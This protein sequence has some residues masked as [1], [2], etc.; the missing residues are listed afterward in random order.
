MNSSRKKYWLSGIILCLVFVLGIF[1]WISVK[2]EESSQTVL[3]HTESILPELPDRERI[4][5]LQTGNGKILF[6]VCNYEQETETLSFLESELLQIAMAEED[7]LDA[8]VT[9]G[10]C[11]YILMI[12]MI[13]GEE[14]LVVKQLQ[15][16]AER[17]VCCLDDYFARGRDDCYQWK[18]AAGG[19]NS[20]YIYHPYGY[21]KFSAEGEILDRETWPDAESYDM[22]ISDCGVWYSYFSGGERKL[23]YRDWLTGDEKWISLPH[24]GTGLWKMYVG[25]T[26]NFYLLE[27]E[28]LFR[29][30]FADSSLHKVLSWSDYGRTSDEMVGLVSDKGNISC[31]FLKN[32]NW[33]ILSWILDQRVE[34]EIVILGG[35]G[36][37][38]TIRS[39]AAHFNQ[40]QEEYL[41]EVVDY[42][43]SYSYEEQNHGIQDLYHAI[44][45]GNGPD[46]IAINTECMDYSAI[47]KNHILEDLIPYMEGSGLLKK[48]DIIQP[49]YN[50]LEYNGA[51]GMIP[52]NFYVRSWMVNRR[53]AG[54]EN[55]TAE[56]ILKIMRDNPEEIDSRYSREELLEILYGNCDAEELR[57][58]IGNG[59][60]GQALEILSSY[61]ES[62]IYESNWNLYPAG[63]IAFLDYGFSGVEDYLYGRAIWGEQGVYLGES[64]VLSPEIYLRNCWGISSRSKHKDVAWSFIES[65]FAKDWLENQASFLGFSANEKYFSRQLEQA[66]EGRLSVDGSVYVETGN[67][68]EVTR[69]DIQSLYDLVYHVNKMGDGNG[70]I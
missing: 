29:Y 56:K 42:G 60:L 33:E 50:L 26:G 40:A 63:K 23:Q 20:F 55:V 64:D 41:I 31:L 37:T 61:P 67:I 2:K 18:I 52:T 65:F 51:V 5:F 57:D 21:M 17:I 32:N 28:G 62:G 47:M 1:L 58:R 70:Q 35:A 22:V 7:F 54:E 9:L 4:S 66:L 69:E 3:F 48:E 59:E 16:M 44:L 53:Y 30:D 43:R 46:I 8:A 19:G 25:E 39:Y 36:I 15:P 6:S 14:H 38:D 11:C 49:V 45:A 34:K 24:K 68:V 13:D 12:V 27:D 10:D